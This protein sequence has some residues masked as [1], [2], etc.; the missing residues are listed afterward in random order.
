MCP[1]YD[2]WEQWER[3]R[4]FI[5]VG[6]TA[7][8]SN[9]K[10]WSAWFEKV[11]GTNDMQVAFTKTDLVEVSTVFLGINHNFNFGPDRGPPILFETMAFHKLATPKEVLSF[12]VEWDGEEQMRCSTWEEA[13]LQHK[14]M[15][16]EVIS[17]EYLGS[18]EQLKEMVETIFQKDTS[19]Q[20]TSDHSE[21]QVISQKE[22]STKKMKED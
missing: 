7:V 5:L 18:P 22:N 1:D 2:S 20:K 4:Y 9:M 11:Y 15:V 3:N 13:E 21:Q 10:G 6:H 16:A 8:P 12:E 19:W 14:I 17:K